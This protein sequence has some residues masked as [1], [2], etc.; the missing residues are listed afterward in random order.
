MDKLTLYLGKTL[1]TTILLSM[2]LIVGLEF[3]FAL[4]NELRYIGTGSYTTLQAVSYILLSIPSRIAQMF[5]MSALVGTLLGLGLL[6]S[7]SELIIMR[8]AGLSLSDIMAAISKLAIVLI[9]SIWVLGEGLAPMLD[10]SAHVQ[11]AIALSSGQ[12]LRT[13]H[14]IWLRDGNNF[15]HIETL[16]SPKEMAGITCY[17][18]DADLTLVKASFAKKAYYRDKQWVFSD[19][20]ESVF[21]EDKVIVN[22]IAEQ[23]WVSHIEPEIL[24]VVGVKDLDELS[25]T[26]LWQTIQYR[27]INQLDVRP[28]ELAFWQKLL[29]PLATLVMMF[30]AI[31]FVFGPLREATMGLRMLVGV[32]VGFVFYTISELFGPLTLVYSLPPFVGALLPSLIFSLFGLW[33]LRHIHR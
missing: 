30:L 18:F 19:V 16:D 31:P 6:A 33:L 24:D 4:V 25:L 27:K 32:L 20:K 9:V 8:A 23:K 28:Y 22:N 17:E 13:M 2:L 26:G 10:K 29:R 11:K 15:I 1:L 5:P 7:R 21:M 12:A 14:G 3:I